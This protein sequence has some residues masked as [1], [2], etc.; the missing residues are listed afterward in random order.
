MEA[1]FAEPPKEVGNTLSISIPVSWFNF[2]V[3]LLMTLDKFGWTMHMLKSPMW[4]LLSQ[5][6]G[7]DKAIFFIFLTNV[8]LL[9]LLFVR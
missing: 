5:T 4:E 8:P 9:M 2:I 3:H 6:E 1:A 7:D